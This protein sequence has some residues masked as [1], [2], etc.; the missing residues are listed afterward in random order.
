LRLAIFGGTFDPIH[1]AHLTVAREAAR[2]CKVDRVLFVPAKAPPHKNRPDAAPY[3]DRYRMVELACAG[4]PLFEPSRLESGEEKSYSIH[5]IERVK[6]GLAPGDELLFIIGADAFADIRTW[7]RWSDVVRAVEFIV[8]AR[9]GHTYEPPP[10]ARIY[11]LDTLS[12]DISSSD[13]R[14][15]IS[16]GEEPSEVPPAVMAYIREK[17]LYRPRAAAH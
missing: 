4:E 15:R 9:P 8:V 13:I 14:A 11:R 6:A 17:G 5:T 10:G 1:S 2:A 12:L 7:H 3:E 16:R